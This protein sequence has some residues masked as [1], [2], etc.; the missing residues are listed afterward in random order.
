M[1]T[2]GPKIRI[3]DNSSEEDS[4][5]FIPESEFSTFHHLKV[6]QC[7]AYSDNSKKASHLPHFKDGRAY[8]PCN[9][10][11]CLKACVCKPCQNPK[12]YLRPGSFKCEKHSIDHPEM[13]DEDEDLAIPRRQFFNSQLKQ[14]NYNRPLSHSFLCPPK[15]KLAQMKRNCQFCKNIFNEH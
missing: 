7:P 6:S 8:Y 5:S 14:P 13:F 12:K 11:S 4:S 15:I 2:W 10:G 3:L 1:G 9:T